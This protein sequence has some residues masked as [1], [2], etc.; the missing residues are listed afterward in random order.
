MTYGHRGMTAELICKSWLLTVQTRPVNILSWKMPRWRPSG[1]LPVLLGVMAL[2]LLPP[3]AAHAQ[4]SVL[5]SLTKALPA[6]PAKD[7]NIHNIAVL[8]PDNR[9]PLPQHY[10]VLQNRI[11]LL[12]NARTNTL[13]SAFCVAPNVIATAAH[14]FFSRKRGQPLNLSGF[15]FRFRPLARRQPSARLEGYRSGLSRLYIAAGTSGLRRRPPIG[16]SRDWALARLDRPYCRNGYL[17]LKPMSIEQLEKASRQRKI[18]QV[19]FHL[20]FK[21]WRLAYSQ[22]CRISRNFGKMRWSSIKNQFLDPDQLVLHDCDTAGASS[23]SPLLMETPQG[24]VAVA[25][26]VGTYQ[27]RNILIRN[28]RII[29]RGRYQTIANTAV[30]AQAFADLT[31]AVSQAP[32]IASYQDIIAMQRQLAARGLYRGA[33]DGIMGAK[34]VKA[35]KSFQRQ[36]NF[37]VT[38][39]PTKQV[40]AALGKQSPQSLSTPAMAASTMAAVKAKALDKNRLIILQLQR[41]L[42]AMGYYN[43]LIDGIFGPQTQNAI[44]AAQARLG[45]PVTGMADLQLL[46]K[47]SQFTNKAQ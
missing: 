25:I 4:L 2:G 27:Q 19:A 13:C 5:K 35:I 14:C 36:Q 33:I 29:K 1:L 22:P 12:H 46:D 30:N 24:L 40:M 37:P 34:M 9:Q 42:A 43:G 31:D 23:G 18:F 38:G 21:N 45:L 28:G 20:D 10:S 39:L 15:R 16:A 7:A 17:P 47:L 6:K 32:V 11:G 41:Q 3:Q 44:R 8:G 26:N